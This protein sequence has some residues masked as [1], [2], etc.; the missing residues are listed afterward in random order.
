MGTT[1]VAEPKGEK[2]DVG[3]KGPRGSKREKGDVGP[4]GPVGATGDT[5]PQRLIGVNSDVA[6]KRLK[7]VVG[8]TGERSMQGLPRDQSGYYMEAETNNLVNRKI[9][10][11]EGDVRGLKVEMGTQEGRG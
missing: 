9:A 5:R 3:P 8:K 6:P 4:K 2:G 1:P 10:T 7:N 11:V